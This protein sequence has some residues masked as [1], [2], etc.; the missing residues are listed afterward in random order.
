MEDRTVCAGCDCARQV[1]GALDESSVRSGMPTDANGDPY[2]INYED[3]GTPY[4]HYA[5]TDSSQP[6]DPDDGNDLRNYEDVSFRTEPKK[7]SQE[8]MARVAR[9][10]GA[11]RPQKGSSTAAQKK[12]SSAAGVAAAA[13]GL[14]KASNVARGRGF[15]RKPGSGRFG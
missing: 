9:G 10:M 7:S 14:G 3:D 4:N 12:S 1:L 8:A 5:V 2:E 6:L 15:G 13:T 11:S